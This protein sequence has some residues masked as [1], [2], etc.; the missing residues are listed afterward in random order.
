MTDSETH[1][2]EY[3]SALL[4]PESIASADAA[5]KMVGSVMVFEME[6]LE[7]VKKLIEGDIYYKTGVVS[8]Q[9][10]CTRPCPHPFP[11][12]GSGAHCHPARRRPSA[13]KYSVNAINTFC[14]GTTLSQHPDCSG[15]KPCVRSLDL[16]QLTFFQQTKTSP[17]TELGGS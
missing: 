12:V 2:A 3:G 10:F 17:Y 9:F 14:S 16:Y 8:P 6:T 5:K 7:D 1:T 13:M 4:T 15:N 11:A